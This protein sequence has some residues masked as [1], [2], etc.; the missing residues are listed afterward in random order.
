M[1]MANE[2]FCKVISI[3]DHMF[4]ERE[5]VVGL[6]K[7]IEMINEGHGRFDGN[8][9]VIAIAKKQDKVEEGNEK[10]TS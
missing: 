8:D 2:N 7:A 9:V 6:N 10:E 3:I 5:N 4:H 1:P